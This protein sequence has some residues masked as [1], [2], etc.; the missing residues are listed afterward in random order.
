MLWMPVSDLS[1]ISERILLIF[2][3]FCRI[4]F[5]S[6]CE[7]SLLFGS[8]LLSGG[9]AQFVRVPKA[10]GTLFKIPPDQATSKEDMDR[11]NSLSDGSLLLLADI[12]PTGVF[13]V[14]QALQHPNILPVINSQPFPVASFVGATESEKSSMHLLTDG[15]PPLTEKD[16]Q[17]TIAVIGLGPVGLVRHLAYT[18]ICIF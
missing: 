7:S 12:L 18:C 14:T 6:R 17:L 16:K 10:G 5:T 15:L 13:A 4:G 8:Q 3:S 9:Q 11:W 1:F 2:G